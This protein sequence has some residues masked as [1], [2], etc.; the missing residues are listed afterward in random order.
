MNILIVLPY[1]TSFHGLCNKTKILKSLHIQSNT[2]VKC[3]M[4]PKPFKSILIN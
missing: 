2:L 4:N 1:T 3:F